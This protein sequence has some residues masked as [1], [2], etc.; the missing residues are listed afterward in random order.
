MKAADKQLIYTLLK[1][2]DA[3]ECGYTREKFAAEPVFTDDAVTP[4]Q[5]MT[6]EPI[7][8]MTDSSANATSGLTIEELNAKILR[9]TRCGLA[10]TRNNVV[11]GMG[12]QTPD[13]LVIGEG[14]GHDEDMQGLPFVGKAGILLDRML[15]AIGLDRKTNCYIANIVKCR[16]PE[17]RNPL[18]DEQSACF[19]F[20]ETQIHILKPKMILCM[21]KIAIEKITGQSI[22]INAQHGEFFDYNGIPV[23]PTY[24]PSA[25]LRN[26]QLKRPAWE[27]LK[28]F[29]KRLDE[30][31]NN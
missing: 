9:C 4:Q 25:L 24:H 7:P 13:V 31:N 12:V 28:L 2:A 27:D 30:I 3:Y 20:L 15:A 10:R 17:N 29:K 16:P 19:S 23:M 11:P 1:T 21:G 18:P 8:T 6:V 26:E 14:P 5:E 22:S